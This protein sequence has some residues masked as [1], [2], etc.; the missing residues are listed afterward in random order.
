M[1]LRVCSAVILC[2]FCAG[3]RLCGAQSLSPRAYVIAPVHSNAVTLSYSLSAGNVVFNDTL[4]VTD[5]SG[6]IGA[7]IASYFHTF[8]CF[9]RSANV[10]VL[11]PYVVGHFK[12]DVNGEYEELYR[13]GLD[14]AAARVS[15]NLI[16]AH[17]MDPQEFSRWRQKTVLGASL[18]V[19][20]PTG[21]YDGRRL[22][23]TGQH[24]WAFKPEI[25]FSQRRGQW[26]LDAYGA[27]WFFTPNDD[28]FSSAPG[29]N[30]PNRQ[31]QEPMGAVEA[32][33]SYD[34]K[35]RMWVSID[36][37]YWY[38]GKTSLNGVQSPTTLQQNS[39]LGA[40]AAIPITRHQSLKFS[41]SGGTYVQ[42]GGNFQ[43]VSAAWQYSWIGRPN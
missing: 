29:S 12:G 43:N 4:P 5:S 8:D 31:T 22:I 23:N 13:S 1:V 33:L 2:S 20:T 14:A 30:G 24:R 26:L 9:G 32:H 25:G 41:Y 37:N 16:G 35:P 15:V 42:F 11:L 6:R 39:R 19:Q 36:S 10:T 38:G 18:L 7:E 21:Q 17:A 34:I 3:P 28:F 40:T 27:V